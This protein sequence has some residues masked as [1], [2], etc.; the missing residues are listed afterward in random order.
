M[1]VSPHFLFLREKTGTE[2]RTLDDFALASRLSYFLWSSMPDEELLDLAA[3][4]A[5]T[6]EMARG[7]KTKPHRPPP[8]H[9]ISPS[10]TLRE[11]VERMLK[12]PKAK[13]FTENFADQWLGLRAID[14]RSHA[15]SGV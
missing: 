5:L 9:P 14:A 8:P 3:K 2:N 12:S 6:G 1:L 13:S 15:L 11:Q 10:A 4:G 7:R